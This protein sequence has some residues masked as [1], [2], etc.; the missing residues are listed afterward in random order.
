MNSKKALV[1]GA[2]S[3]IGELFARELAKEGYFIT[4]VARRE[5]RLQQL[6]QE[7]GDGHHYLVADLTDRAQLKIVEQ[8]LM[9]HKY[10]LLVNNAGYAIYNHFSAVSLERHENLMSLNMNALVRLTYVFLEHAAGG[11]ALINVASALSRLTFPGGA[12]Y[13]GTKAFVTV[14]TESLWY[15]YKDKGIYIMA[16]LPGM[17]FTDFLEV[18]LDGQDTSWPEVLGHPPKVVVKEAIKALKRRKVPSLISGW[19]YRFLT[20]LANRLVGRRKMIEI[21]GKYNPTQ[22]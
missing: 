20:N 3:G 15:E 17:T 19:K 1:T 7:L 22:G 16:L 6:V 12:I 18:S 9:Q 10:Q 5:E 14:F 21:M 8:E 13:A 11:D 4:G 2:S